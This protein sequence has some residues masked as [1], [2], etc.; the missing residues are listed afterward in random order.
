MYASFYHLLLVMHYYSLWF[1]VLCLFGLFVWTPFVV[2]YEVNIIIINLR[3]R[4][5][6]KR[7]LRKKLTTVCIYWYTYTYA[8]LLIY[9]YKYWYIY[10]FISKYTYFFSTY[11][12]TYMNNWLIYR[13]SCYACH[14]WYC[15]TRAS[16]KRGHIQDLNMP[17][18][19]YLSWTSSPL[20]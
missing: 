7:W 17:L 1:Y 11:I 4:Q 6:R 12:Y 5:Q 18:Y 2:I 15:S 14:C 19:V 20:L 8:H 13:S 10:I 9:L 3:T 16:H